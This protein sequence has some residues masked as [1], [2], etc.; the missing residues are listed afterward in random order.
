[1]SNI[2]D[3]MAAAVAQEP[4]SAYTAF[5]AEMETRVAEKIENLKAEVINKMFNQGNQND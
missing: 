5:D 2:A 3:F 4:S 1:M